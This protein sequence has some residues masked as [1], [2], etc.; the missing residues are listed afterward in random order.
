MLKGRLGRLAVASADAELAELLAEG[1][2]EELGLE[3]DEAARWNTDLY[4]RRTRL[5][6]MVYMRLGEMEDEDE[7]EYLAEFGDVA[8]DSEQGEDSH[9]QGL[10][11]W[12]GAIFLTSILELVAEECL[13]VAGQAAFKRTQA[14]RAVQPAGVDT[15]SDNVQQRV[16]VIESDV[17][18]AGIDSRLGRLWR[19]WKHK[20]RLPYQDHTRNFP[21]PRSSMASR[22]ASVSTIQSDAYSPLA[23]KK[24]Q[25]VGEEAEQH[26]VEDAAED[27]HAA[28]DPQE[29]S[30]EARERSERLARLSRR[31]LSLVGLPDAKS[32][33]LR[34]APASDDE[35]RIRQRSR[36][37]T[38]PSPGSWQ[39]E[40]A[41]LV[42]LQFQSAKEVDNG[43][44]A[45]FPRNIHVSD[46]AKED[47]ALTTPSTAPTSNALSTDQPHESTTAA[48]PTTGDVDGQLNNAY[49]E[50]SKLNPEAD[51]T[52]QDQSTG[53]KSVN[54]SAAM[55]PVIDHDSSR[56]SS[57]RTSIEDDSRPVSMAFPP[58]THGI[59][60][61]PSIDTSNNPPKSMQVVPPP[62]A[63]VDTHY[64]TARSSPTT[65]TSGAAASTFI[66]AYARYGDNV[67][68][69][70]A[71]GDKG[72]FRRNSKHSKSPSLKNFRKPSQDTISSREAREKELRDEI[73]GKH[74]S[75]YIAG[76]ETLKYTLTPRQLQNIEVS[77]LV[78]VIRHHANIV[79]EGR[80]SI[81]AQRGDSDLRKRCY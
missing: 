59:T 40:Q 2:D 79:T 39:H 65:P 70:D 8:Q 44:E 28:V 42:G 68:P 54:S 7:E 35:R 49:S 32:W 46:L 78:D 13:K 20:L 37:Q 81:T 80:L 10:V 76:K 48:N 72:W 38:L 63:S 36:P 67:T 1:E 17:D 30:D 52:D 71:A 45:S 61:P 73:A 53:D 57:S 55:T 27:E 11:S 41:R 26:A 15:P 18:K 56:R 25:A 23:Q 34:E 60:V 58:G 24:Q 77:F 31:P 43:P 19:S 6:I 66:P 47:E 16:T 50:H 74:F 64:S 14:K 21:S 3:E 33:N 69:P 12:A 5:R 9:D 51:G 22:G 4:F 62:P 29:V 75:S